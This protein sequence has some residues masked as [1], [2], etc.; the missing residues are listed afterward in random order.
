M[1]C[2]LCS[3]CEA[4]EEA[5]SQAQR[6]PAYIV[7]VPQSTVSEPSVDPARGV[8]SALLDQFKECTFI[9]PCG[10][11]C[12]TVARLTG[13]PVTVLTN[14]VSPALVAPSTVEGLVENGSIDLRVPFVSQVEG[15]SSRLAATVRQAVA[16]VTEPNQGTLLQSALDNG[17]CVVCDPRIF[18]AGVTRFGYSENAPVVPSS[19][20]AASAWARGLFEWMQPLRQT[21]SI[22]ESGKVR[23]LVP[24]PE[25]QCHFVNCWRTLAALADPTMVD[26]I[27][28]CCAQE[29]FC[30]SGPSCDVRG[31]LRN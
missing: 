23:V 26:A 8:S 3:C 25:F 27:E 6:V 11:V 17:L 1:T 22:L 29:L 9:D 24:N 16:H 13:E 7:F 30:A 2:I 14:T 5:R 20:I 18:A 21:G 10:K 12:S 15:I 4:N 19:H 28:P 31:P